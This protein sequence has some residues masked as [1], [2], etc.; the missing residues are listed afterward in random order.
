MEEGGSC[1]RE[2]AVRGPAVKSLVPVT[3]ITAQWD[4]IPT[5]I[6]P[7]FIL[8]LFFGEFLK[9]VFSGES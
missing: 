9:Q 6:L 3:P 7:F 5:W 1:N 8:F 2:I 4:R